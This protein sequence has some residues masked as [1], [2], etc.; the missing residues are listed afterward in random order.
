MSQ[1]RKSGRRSGKRGLTPEDL[2]VWDHV[3]KGVRPIARQSPHRTSPSA[4]PDLLS[5]SSNPP[6]DLE[7]AFTERLKAA[8][9][10]SED[11]AVGRVAI[12]AKQGTA[13]EARPREPGG[14]VRPR[15]PQPGA[16][17]GANGAPS[18]VGLDAKLARRIRRGQIEIDARL[19]LHGMTQAMAHAA[20]RQFLLRCTAQNM[21]TV[22][23]ITG[24]GRAER[25]NEAGAWWAVGDREPK[26]VLRRNLPDW[27]ADPSMKP[28][29]LGYE[30]A[31]H[32]HGGSGAFYVR[33]RRR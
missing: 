23:V 17:A 3:A 25:E 19:D 7:Q 13:P 8:Q 27:L 9:G 32:Q 10:S 33:L 20:L 31:A 16:P 12:G 4:D 2:S 22:L 14:K 24:K 6:D 28:L 29:I 26:G 30:T 1:H 11:R 5:G 18:G 21:R 15:V